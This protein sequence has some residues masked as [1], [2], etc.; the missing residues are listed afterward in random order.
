MRKNTLGKGLEALIGN[1]GEVSEGAY[2]TLPTVRLKP[3]AWQPRTEFSSKTI[4]ELA[5]SIREKGVIQPLIVRKSGDKYEIIAGER[6][7]RAAQ[8]AG[9]HE[10]P[11]IVRE[12]AG[13]EL[14]EMALIE[15]IQREDLNPVEEALAYERLISEFGL[16]HENM[17]KRVGRSRA[18][19]TNSLRLLNLSDA[20]REALV[21]GKISTG[22]ARAILGLKSR[23]NEGGVVS[24]SAGGLS[25]RQTEALVKKLN[26]AGSP[27]GKP[28]AASQPDIYLKR[29]ERSMREALSAKVSIKGGRDRG[30]IMIEYSSAED[31]ERLSFEIAGGS[32]LP[33][34]AETE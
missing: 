2:M 25:V 14:L 32:P 29:A 19:I 4:D 30:S 21:S 27:A 11:V 31:L 26:S 33:A 12:A 8:K 3:G 15:N 24:Q 17:S 28:P 34:R 1:E 23:D 6:R 16:T 10:V 7:W 5:D 13:G 18:A 9:I 22:H 20:A